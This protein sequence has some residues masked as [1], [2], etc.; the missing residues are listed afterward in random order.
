MVDHEGTNVFLQNKI[1]HL[2]SLCSFDFFDFFFLVFLLIIGGRIREKIMM[3]LCRMDQFYINGQDLF[4][5][6]TLKAS[7]I[8]SI[9]HN[10]Y[11]SGELRS[12]K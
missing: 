2:F 4:K 9:I 10:W 7:K 8:H 12:S 3:S 1:S 6:L 11:S 5:D